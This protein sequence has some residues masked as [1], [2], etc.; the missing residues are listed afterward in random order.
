MDA[1]LNSVS[2]GTF[3][4]RGVD[5]SLRNGVWRHRA[6]PATEEPHPGAPPKDPEKAE[7]RREERA[8]FFRAAVIPKLKIEI[9]NEGLDF[10]GKTRGSMCVRELTEGDQTIYEVVGVHLRGSAG[11]FRGI[12]A[13]PGFTIGWTSSLR[14]RRFMG[15]KSSTSAIALKTGAS[16]PRW[17][18]RAVSP[19]WRAGVAVHARHRN[20]ERQVVRAWTALKE[21]YD[22][23]FLEVHFGNRDGNFYDGGFLTDIDQELH[24]APARTM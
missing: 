8:S 9:S 19:G 3:S 12:D 6:E 7:A 16:S 21:G 13:R 10:C 24:L 22:G 2:E 15:W 17:P 11:S 1:D 4:R 20:A 5:R 23:G 18:R 14:G